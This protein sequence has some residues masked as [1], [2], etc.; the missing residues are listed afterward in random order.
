MGSVGDEEA[1]VTTP[2]LNPDLRGKK[3]K[4]K[5]DTAQSV[6]TSNPM[7]NTTLRLRFPVQTC[8]KSGTRTVSPTT[9]QAER[10]MPADWAPFVSP[11]TRLLEG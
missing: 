5:N 1:D 9:K 2:K 6:E 7:I 8:T 10:S 3:R 4:G 11:L